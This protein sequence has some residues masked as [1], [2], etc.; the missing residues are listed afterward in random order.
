MK[1]ILLAVIGLLSFTGVPAVNYDDGVFFVN[2]DWY[3]HN[4]STINFLSAN[5]TWNYR[6][7][8]NE[9]PGQ[10]LGASSPYGTVYGDKLYIISKQDK[11]PN[12]EICGSR[13]AVC[14]AKTL[15]VI[16]AFTNLG[17]GGDG[18]SFIGVN[19]HKGYIA[20]SNGIWI[21]DIDKMEIGRMIEGT[22]TTTAGL[23]TNQVG[24]MLRVGDHVFA[25]HQ[26][27]GIFVINPYNDEVEKTFAG[28]YG[29]IVMSKDGGVWASVASKSGT[30][31]DKIVKIDSYTLAL[32]EYDLP[33]GYSIPNSWYAWTADGFCASKQEN[34]LYWKNNGGWFSSKKIYSYDIATN[35][36]DVVI[37]LAASEWG[38]YGAGFRINPITDEIYCSMYKSFDSQDYEVMRISNKGKILQEY[39]MSQNYWFPAMP[40]FPDNYAP[41]ISSEF[42][43]IL[44]NEE[45][46]INLD[47]KVS[48]KDNLDAAIIKTI[49][50]NDNVAVVNAKILN[51]ILVLTPTS[52]SGNA[53]ITIEFNSNGKIA[54]KCINVKTRQ[55]SVENNIAH[56]S[57]NVYPNPTSSYINVKANIGSSISIYTVCGICLF[58]TIADQQNTNISMEHL[59]MGMYIVKIDNTSIRIIKQ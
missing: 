55:A 25:V 51:N 42:T 10:E 3:G 40:V 22:G 23:Y 56:N 58:S 29:S 12:A 39:P 48:D 31:A 16:K 49:V 15:K 8:Q 28:F 52:I 41:E 47:D 37:D 35:T 17:G 44:I 54:T 57:V 27:K 18:R 32:N 26:S 14:D 59:S 19:S 7:F 13:M 53:N 20:T 43:D 24:S 1:K 5:G 6:V 46:L 2:E 33:K 9:N 11:D 34:K 38:I 21:Y 45:T 36:V 30:A 4:N 50:N